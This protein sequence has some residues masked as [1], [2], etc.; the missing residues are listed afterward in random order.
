MVHSYTSI[1][2]ILEVITVHGVEY[3]IPGYGFLSE[4]EDFATAVEKCGAVFVGPSPE[5]LRTFGIKDRARNIASKAGLPIVP[6]SEIV[7]S[8]KEALSE[9]ERIGYPVCSISGIF[10]VSSD[11]EIR[12]C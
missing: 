2:E 9:A 1:P 6:G 7:S 12:L 3:V 11:L 5:L 4:N 8:I 10:Y